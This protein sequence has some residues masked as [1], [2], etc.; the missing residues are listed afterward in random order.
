MHSKPR[1][2]NVIFGARP[3]PEGAAPAIQLALLFLLLFLTLTAQPAQAQ[4]YTIIHIFTDQE[5]GGSPRAG[6]T[7]DGHGNLYGTTAAGGIGGTGAVFKMSRKNSDWILTPLYNFTLTGKDGAEPIGGVIRD[8]GGALYGT[9]AVGGSSQS[10]TVFKLRPS[11]LAPRSATAAWTESILHNFTRDGSDGFVPGST[12]VFDQAGNLYGTTERGGTYNDGTVFKLTPSS[13]AWTES[14]LYSF[15]GIDGMEP[16]A[17]VVRDRAGNLYGTTWLG[18]AYDCGTVF[19]LTPAGSG[20]TESVLYSFMG[21]GDGC[22][23]TA[24][25]I[26][27]GAGN[28]YGATAMT[29]PQDYTSGGTVF[30]LTPSNGR[31]NY[32]L[33]YTF[34]SGNNSQCSSGWGSGPAAS[35]TLDGAGALYG[36]TQGSGAYGYGNVFKLAPLNGGWVYTSLHDFNPYNYDGEFPCSSVTFDANGNLYGTTY[37]GGFPYLSG[38]VWEITP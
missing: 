18:G 9:T 8:A 2:Q 1:F 22:R 10:G 23:P 12:L 30:Q 3:Q 24:G 16:W 34:P 25:V 7:I 14:I 35:M 33:L 38:V 37:G 5:D 27:D 11:P 28:L 15:T 20:W 31:W 26:L 17:D 21:N 36:T 6:V 32:S 4:T 13:G 29:N 19:Q